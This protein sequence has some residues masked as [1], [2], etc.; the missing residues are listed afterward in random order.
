MLSSKDDGQIHILEMLTLFWL[1]FSTASFLLRV[2]VPNPNSPASD[3][4]MEYAARDAI[5]LNLGNETE[6]GPALF[7]LSSHDSSQACSVILEDIPV[8]YLGRCWISLNHS[9]LELAF[10][11]GQPEGRSVTA[12]RMVV[13]NDDV[14]TIGIQIW[15]I[16]GGIAA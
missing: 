14:W 5:E 3:G 2:D 6:L 7:H 4:A 1:F 13:V 9:E 12:Y 11:D 15:P 16:G 8:Q 10:S